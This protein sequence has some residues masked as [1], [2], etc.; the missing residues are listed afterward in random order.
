MA[1]VLRERPPPPPLSASIFGLIPLALFSPLSIVIVV[2]LQ[3]VAVVISSSV[4][5]SPVSDWTP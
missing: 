2:I 4:V 3:L 1:T 5:A